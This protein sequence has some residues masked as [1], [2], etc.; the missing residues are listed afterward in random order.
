VLAISTD[1]AHSLG[2]AFGV[3]LSSRPRTIRRRLDAVELDAPRAFARWM[4][5]HRSA[6]ADIVEHGTWLDRSD[7]DSLLDL[8]IPG[9]DELVGMLE[10]TRLAGENDARYDVIVVDMAPTGHALRFMSAPDAVAVVADALD[11]L[12]ENHRLVREQLARVPGPDAADG[13][14]AL[15]ARQSSRLAERLRDRH[16]TTFVWVTLAEALAVAESKDGIAALASAGVPVAEIVVNRM[17]LDGGSCPVCGPRARSETQQ[18]RAIRKLAGRSPLRIVPA[19]VE[20]PRGVRRLRTLSAFLT[21]TRRLAVAGRAVQ[22][23][24]GGR[25]I[26]RRPGERSIGIDALV[27]RLQDARL[28]FVGGKGGVGKTTVAAALALRLAEARKDRSILLLSTDPAH[29]VSDV[30]GAR[31]RVAAQNLSTCELDAVRAFRARRDAMESALEQIGTTAGAAARIM[32][33]APPGIDELFAMLAIV[34]ARK[35]YDGMVV[36]TAPTGHA[37]RLLAMPDAAR[38]WVQVLMR[39]LLKYQKVVHPGALG[40]ELVDASRSIRNLQTLLQDAAATRFVVVTRAERLPREET[41]RL[42]ARLRSFHIVPGALVFNA[43][44]LVP[45]ACPRC[46]ATNRAERRQIAALRRPR[47]CAII[48]APLVA[49]PPRGAA[50]LR[51]WSRSWIADRS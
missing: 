19:M 16:L 26:S 23:K 51:R 50:A 30:F 9:V 25:L 39:L 38:M 22:R 2:D 1:P 27:R 20:E 5:V 45:G 31:M 41:M 33:L 49:P 34:D 40:A 24:S 18:L 42:L 32:E 13:M 17:L 46:Q 14:I 28:I 47:G 21:G 43:R 44:T 37:L 7:A 11:A 8:P 6:L 3:A 10:M 48:Q 4:A 36:D 29:S 35:A 12:H 15:L